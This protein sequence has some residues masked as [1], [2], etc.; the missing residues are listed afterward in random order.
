MTLPADQVVL[1]GELL[2]DGSEK[3]LQGV[4]DGGDN[5]H[6]GSPFSG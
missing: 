2:G 5:G 1:V 6:A 3:G 4:G